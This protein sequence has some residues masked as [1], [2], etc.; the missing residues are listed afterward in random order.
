MLKILSLSNKA[1][2]SLHY[3]FPKTGGGAG[4]EEFPVYIA[5]VEG[6]PQC[7]GGIL[8]TSDLQGIEINSRKLIGK[9]L[10]EDIYLLSGEGSIPEAESIGVILAG[11]LHVDINLEKRGGKGDVRDVWHDFAGLF[12]WVAGIAGNHD[13]FGKKSH[14]LEEFKKGE[15]IYYLDG[16]TV[17]VDSLLIGGVGGITGNPLKPFRREEEEYMA[18]VRNIMSKSPD[19][20]ILHESPEIKEAGYRGSSELCR[21]LENMPPVLVVTGHCHWEYPGYRTMAKGVQVLNV[22]GRAVLLMRNP[23]PQLL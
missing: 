20:L 22:E 2:H 10:A 3:S 11:D 14:D 12:K 18:L 17:I 6:L 13:R 21:C 23:I 4:Y 15:N 19:L 1:I 8:I 7:L 16:D 9:T 5:H